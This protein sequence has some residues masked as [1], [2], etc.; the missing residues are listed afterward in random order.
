MKTTVLSKGMLY[1]FPCQ[2]GECRAY[3]G[4]RVHTVEQG[5]EFVMLYQFKGYER[6]ML[7]TI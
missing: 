7:S 2:F 5:L 4:F 6:M 1:G 3:I